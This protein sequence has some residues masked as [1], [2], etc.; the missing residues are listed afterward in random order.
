[1][2]QCHY[3]IDCGRCRGETPPGIY[4]RRC[5]YCHALNDEGSIECAACGRSL[6]L[7]PT[8]VHMELSAG[9]RKKAQDD[10]K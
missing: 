3:C 10:P 8:H 7:D 2:G 4:V 1:M 6:Y 9:N 5:L